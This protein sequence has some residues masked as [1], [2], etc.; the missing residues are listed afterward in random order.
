MT[1]TT[2]KRAAGASAAAKV[3]KPKASKVAKATKGSKKISPYNKYMKTEL[4]KVKQD[5]PSLS[6]KD[7]FKLV[8]SNWKN[9]PEN[10][11]AVAAAK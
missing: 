11:R 7:A 5:N 2:T 8:A 3:S 9:A 10:P 6:H 1:T 4:A